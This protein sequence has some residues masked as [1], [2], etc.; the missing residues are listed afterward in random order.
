MAKVAPV[1]P[2][3]SEVTSP[4]AEM[5][6]L[7]VMDLRKNLVEIFNSDKEEHAFFMKRSLENIE[8]I[9]NLIKPDVF[10]SEIFE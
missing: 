3:G 4:L 5:L 9:E 2:A 7:E 8:T 1:R 10:S 6:M